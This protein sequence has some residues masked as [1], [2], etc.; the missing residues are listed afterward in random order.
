[1]YDFDLFVDTW[2]LTHEDHDGF[3]RVA[4][5]VLDALGDL[6]RDQHFQFALITP[7]ELW[8]RLLPSFLI[9]L[10]LLFLLL[11]LYQI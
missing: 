3:A 8:L 4:H 6:Q 10:R 5:F 7:S 1:M 11:F 9:T 2:V